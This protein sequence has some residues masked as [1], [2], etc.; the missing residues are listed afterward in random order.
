[1][2]TSAE[3]SKHAQNLSNLRHSTAHLLAHA[4]TELYP[5]TLLTIGPVTDEGFFYD[6]LPTTNFKEEELAIIEARMHEIAAR[7][8]PI[9]QEEI[10]KKEAQ[11]LF[12]DNPYKLELIE[13]ITDEMVGI[14]RQGDFF[15]LCR[16]GHVANTKNIKHFKLTAT[17]GSYWRADKTKQ[18]LQRIS[19]TAFESQQE[20]DEYEQLKKDAILYDHRR[21]G[22]Q[23]DLF[24][25]SDLAAGFPF[26]HPKGCA[27]LNTMIAYMRGLQR[28]HHYQEVLTPVMM[29]DELWKTS[30]HYY[31][32]KDN[33]YFADLEDASYAIKPMNCPGSIL[34]Y[35]SRPRSYRELP[36]RM[37]EFGHVVRRELSGV[38]HGLMRVRG[39]TQD[40]AH[41]YCTKDQLE[42]QIINIIKI[43]KEMIQ[44]FDIKNMHFA[45]AT[46][47]ATK[48]IGS[49]ELWDTATNAL[50]TALERVGEPYRIKEG[51]GAFYGPK[52]EV[53]IQDSMKRFWQC[54]T[55]Q[56]DFSLPERF[57]IHYIT[58]EGT[59]ERP[60]MIHQANFGSLERFFGILVE[61]Y[62][63]N[64][65][66]WL[67]PV[68]ARVLPITDAQR[69]YA[70][71]LY[72]DLYACGYRVEIDT[73]GDPLSGQI[74]SAQEEKIPLMI[75]I[76][77]KEEEAK[78]VT[79]RH[80]DGKQEMGLDY[81][82]LLCRFEELQR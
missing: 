19:G 14:S 63:G 66:F 47:P 57:D 42:D 38:L 51:E 23:M 20:L 27:V 5:D 37:S 18:A 77:K 1:M 45:I 48:Y 69:T 34:I 28:K 17:S 54:S 7:A 73:S 29:S 13:N 43:I 25:I 31:F 30:G 81:Q 64:F 71:K 53:G 46:K 22:K 82:A 4:V 61:H 49:D 59:K 52:I 9:T 55:V 50:K 35:A 68:Q 24:S 62:K 76:G 67:A 8:L 75:V 72:E 40:D 21:L 80:R 58:K 60:I 36:L 3:S 78:T 41:T 26:F 33:M 32:Y 15:D 39:F 2:K 70:Q 74:K 56:V 65:P 6:F 16:G 79:L 44:K 10:S 11:K 12:A